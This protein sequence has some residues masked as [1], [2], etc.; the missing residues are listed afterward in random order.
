MRPESEAESAAVSAATRV[1]ELVRFPA[2][3]VLRDHLAVEEPLEVRIEGAPYAV[4]MRTPGHDRALVAG[5]LRSEG[6]IEGADDLAALE[7]CADPHRPHGENVMLVRLASGVR[8]PARPRA[9]VSST[10]CGVCGKD[11]IEAVLRHVPPRPSFAPV[12]TALL[13]QL[14]ERLAGLQ[15]LFA[16]TGGTHAAVLFGPGP[17]HRVLAVAEDV[18]RHNATDKVIGALL[19]AGALPRTESILWLSGRAGFEIVEKA[20]RA[21]LSTVVAVGAP[22]SLA[23]ELAHEGRLTLIAFARGRDAYNVMRP[24]R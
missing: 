16:V 23:V 19:L 20:L 9:L 3:L 10:S 8:R 13:G 22:T 4:L 5:F 15:P 1:T 2:G 18:G 11:R 24:T 7:P 14:S 21:G 17:D 12:P 6:V